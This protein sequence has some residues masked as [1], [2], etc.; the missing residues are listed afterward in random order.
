MKSVF[1]FHIS[2]VLIVTNSFAQ[3]NYTLG[4]EF[5][6]SKHTPLAYEP[7]TLVDQINF[8]VV[9]KRGKI[10]RYTKEYNDN[11]SL[12]CLSK[13]NKDGVSKPMFEFQY[14]ED[15]RVV[16]AK[17]YKKEKLNQTILMKYNA[18][19]KIGE[20]KKIN[21]KGMVVHHQEWVYNPDSTLAT[22]TWFDSDGKISHKWAYEY[23]KKDELK[24]TTLYNRRGKVK[25]IWSY[26][27]KSEGEVLEK[28]KNETQVCQWDESSKD[29]L[30]KVYQSFD[31]KGHIRK[32]VTKYNAADTSIV[33]RKSYDGND[34]LLWESTFDGSY[35]KQLTS[36]GYN[37]KGR[38]KY[39]YLYTYDGELVLSRTGFKKGKQTWQQKYTYDEELL[40][41]FKSIKGDGKI[42]RKITLTYG[43]DMA[44]K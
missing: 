40:T 8:K 44:G 37:K 36:I 13:F 43:K 20:K 22:Y 24:R 5:S 42:T 17:K 23:F 34:R 14:N 15:G 21:S 39:K 32:Y 2:I 30:I 33:E 6:Q 31:E 9:L 41:E 38:E 4:W 19:G 25:K 28:R 10:K 26:E 16:E 12:I 7:T 3:C 35:S 11:G 1:L 29:Y 18:I 27:C